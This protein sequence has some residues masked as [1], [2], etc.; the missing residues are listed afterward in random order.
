M[1]T[2]RQKVFLASEER[3]R[4][5]ISDHVNCESYR[6][7]WAGGTLLP[8]ANRPRELQRPLPSICPDVQRRCW[9]QCVCATS[10]CARDESS[11]A[12]RCGEG[13]FLRRACGP[14]LF[15]PTTPR[16]LYS[17]CSGGAIWGVGDALPASG[18][19]SQR[20]AP[21]RLLGPGRAVS[22][23][24]TAETSARERGGRENRWWR[25]LRRQWLSHVYSVS[26]ACGRGATATL[27]R[28]GALL[29]SSK[30]AC[31]ARYGSGSGDRYLAAGQT[32]SRRGCVQGAT[33]PAG[34]GTWRAVVI[35]GT[36]EREDGTY[37]GSTGWAPPRCSC[38]FQRQLL[39]PLHLQSG[40][41]QERGRCK[42]PRCCEG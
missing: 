42:K 17:I 3:V 9:R 40:A 27:P 23:G 32:S 39:S 33:L 24:R 26:R 28:R 25:P 2:L 41:I 8:V 6:A 13:C 20:G 38:F 34:R 11:G 30:S 7:L 36:V 1:V 22:P 21:G 18:G 10:A 15:H 14:S 37:L 29:C 35:A 12:S 19:W 4:K 31:W 5:K 16:R